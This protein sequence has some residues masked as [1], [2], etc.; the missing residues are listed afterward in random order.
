MKSIGFSEEQ[1][2]EIVEIGKRCGFNMN[3]G[4]NGQKSKF[5][6]V[7]A[8]I[9]EIEMNALKDGEKEKEDEFK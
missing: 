6:L 3:A 9:A 8:R 7:A 4:R 1:Y 5:L 2:N